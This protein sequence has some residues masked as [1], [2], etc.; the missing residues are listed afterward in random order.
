MCGAARPCGTGT[1]DPYTPDDP[2]RSWNPQVD[3]IIGMT[4]FGGDVPPVG[5]VGSDIRG[6][7]SRFHVIG[8]E[9]MENPA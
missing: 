9:A 5:F 4:S 1:S 2:A 7:H 6:V 8:P 3:E